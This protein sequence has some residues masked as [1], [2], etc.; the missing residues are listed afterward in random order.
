MNALLNAVI[1]NI[2]G[3]I[4][5]LNELFTPDNAARRLF[6]VIAVN[7]N[8][9]RIE[10]EGGSLITI[11]RGA[12]FEA[13]RYLL[14]NNHTQENPCEIRSSQTAEEAGPLCV[15]TRMVNSNVRVIN[16]IV[17]ILA[18]VGVLGVSGRR[19]NTTWLI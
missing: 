8:T 6:R 1:E 3:Q 2:W 10:T 15:T 11:H 7:E 9:V 5:D 4:G 16:Y 17:P 12:F 14:E 18:A 13:L 19:P